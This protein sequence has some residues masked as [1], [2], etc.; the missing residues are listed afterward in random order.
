MLQVVW[1]ATSI[2]ADRMARRKLWP[3]I[4][5]SRKAHYKPNADAQA[6]SAFIRIQRKRTLLLKHWWGLG[7]VALAERD[8]GQPQCHR[9]QRHN[10]QPERVDID[11][12]DA[13]CERELH[14]VA[15]L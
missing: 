8:L 14:R 3:R 7:A 2:E 15:H 5:R 9:H 4:C 10:R 6:A 13:G 1:R 12:R 11:P